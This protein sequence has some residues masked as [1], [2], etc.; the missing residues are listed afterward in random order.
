MASSSWP[1]WVF[2]LALAA[3]GL[4][5]LLVLALLFKRPRRPDDV[6]SRGEVQQLIGAAVGQH[7]ERLERE[8]RQEI[9]GSAREGRQEL[10]HALATFQDAVVRQGA[11]S[12]RT[13]NAQVDA[14][15]A[16]LTQLR[17]TLGDTLVSQL[18]ALGLGMAQQA[19]EA[20]RTQNAQIDA[21][22]QQLAHLR[23]SLSETL[24]QQ[25]QQLS[26]TNARSARHAGA[27]A[28]P[29]ASRQHRQARRD[30]ADGG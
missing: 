3:L 25:L 15:A 10:S 7:G 11:E 8:L 30:A 12:V 17:G 2:W 24:T 1:D 20:T 6:A 29:A 28:G 19:A 22:A 27:A 4:N 5:L 21:F 23:G 14:L 16:Q 9:G 13:Q 26:E 18:Q